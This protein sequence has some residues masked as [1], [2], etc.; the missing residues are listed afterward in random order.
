METMRN[1]EALPLGER[2]AR[3]LRAIALEIR[4]D[5]TGALLVATAHDA[6]L[7]VA[8]IRATEM[9][10][11]READRAWRVNLA[12][13]AADGSMI[14][15]GAVCGHVAETLLHAE[16]L[17][18]AHVDHRDAVRL[19]ALPLGAGG[20]ASEL[21]A[22]AAKRA[23]AARFAAGTVD[24]ANSAQPANPDPTLPLLRRLRMI[25][26]AA[27]DAETT[28]AAEGSSAHA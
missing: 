16:T 12:G 9:P 28:P 6:M 22:D 26:L 10:A 17:L 24:V 2:R 15:L 25:A 21:P 3:T 23:L 1:D 11:R 18:L 14:D 19:V 13:E 4:I 5:A 27:R 8:R 7:G 20:S